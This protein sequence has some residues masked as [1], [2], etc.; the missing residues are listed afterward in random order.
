MADALPWPSV[1]VPSSE[2][3]APRGG[4]R[5]GGQTFEGNEQIVASPSAR[6]KATLTIPCLTRDANLAMRRVIA[7]GR[8]QTWNVGPIETNRAPWNIDFV[9]GKVTYRRGAKD[10][11]VNPAFQS[12]PTTSSVLDFKLAADAAMNAT[13]MTIRRN[14]GGVLEPGMVFSL[15]NRLHVVTGLPGG[16]M[17]APGQPGPKGTIPVEFRP[18]LRSDY[19]A[20]TG[21]EFGAPVGT[22]RLAADDAGSLDLQLSKSGIVTLDLVEAF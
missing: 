14:Q 12:D 22:M 3:W 16:E 21:I 1:L 9:G 5:S 15:G 17:A 19:G 2:N 10:N 8:S 13:S 11:G 20:N 7:L 4:S 18:W 6:W